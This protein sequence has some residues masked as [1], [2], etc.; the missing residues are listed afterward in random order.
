MHKLD[1]A[2]EGALAFLSG[3]SRASPTDRAVPWRA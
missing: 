2:R 1:D 3:R